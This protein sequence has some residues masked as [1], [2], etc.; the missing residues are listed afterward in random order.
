MALVLAAVVLATVAE[1]HRPSGR[2][3]TPVQLVLLFTGLLLAIGG[4]YALV[5]QFS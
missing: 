3:G 2:I 1:G 4:F 5:A